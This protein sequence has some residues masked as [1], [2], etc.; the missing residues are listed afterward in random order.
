MKLHELMLSKNPKHWT[1]KGDCHSYTDYYETIFSK[2]RTKQINLLEVGIFHGS[3]LYL[4]DNYF[5]HQDTI[6]YGLDIEDRIYPELKDLYSNR[7]QYE[8]GK[9]YYDENNI[10]NEIKQT[11]WDIIIDDGSHTLEHQID[12]Y[13]IYKEFLKN[14]GILII[15]DIQ[16][17][18][19]YNLILE[20]FPETRGIDLR[21]N[22]DRYD[23]LLIVKFNS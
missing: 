7:V 6:I 10:P 4:W 20:K 8:I 21:A 15:E 1:D 11:K 19:N 14:D 9:N 13:E 3:S 5:E 22:K 18:K 16:S 2:Y 12:F 17:V 23:D